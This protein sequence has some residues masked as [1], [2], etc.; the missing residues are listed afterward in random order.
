LA[1]FGSLKE[2]EIP[3]IRRRFMPYTPHSAAVAAAFI[4]IDQRINKTPQYDSSKSDV[5]NWNTM[6]TKNKYCRGL[7]IRLVK[8]LDAENAAL[9]S[10]FGMPASGGRVVMVNGELLFDPDNENDDTIVRRSI[11]VLDPDR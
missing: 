1:V 10:T 8:H 5:E 2:V 6:V 11:A 7:L 9:R 3:P 4:E